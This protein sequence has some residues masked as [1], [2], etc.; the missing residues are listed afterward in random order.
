MKQFYGYKN[1]VNLGGWLSQCGYEKEH[2]AG[3]ITEADIDRI[4]S[5]GCDHVRLPFD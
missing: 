4:A 3:F 1:G 5:W 2:I